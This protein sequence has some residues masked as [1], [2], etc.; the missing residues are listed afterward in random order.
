MR[1]LED[2][3]T[4]CPECDSHLMLTLAARLQA[5]RLGTSCHCEC[6]HEWICISEWIYRTAPAPVSS[7]AIT[8]PPVQPAAMSPPRPYLLP[9]YQPP[10]PVAPQPA[11]QTSGVPAPATQAT[12]A[13][14]NHGQTPVP[15]PHAFSPA[16]NPLPANSDVPRRPFDP[17][18]R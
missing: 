4:L 2:F 7:P 16:T 6:G 9:T 13:D 12:S 18:S 3:Y 5:A 11:Q 17:N 10:L 14:P 1:F 15:A 8:A